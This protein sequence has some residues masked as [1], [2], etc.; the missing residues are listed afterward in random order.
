MDDR[1]S[2][3]LIV[4]TIKI[5]MFCIFILFFT[6][7]IVATYLFLKFPSDKQIKGC[8]IT[9]FNKVN[10]CA[11]SENYVKLSEISEYLIKAVI[12]TEDTAFYSHSGFD[13]QEIVN[14]FKLN[15]EKGKFARGGSTISQQLAKNLFLSK[16]KTLSRKLLE[17]LITM[18]IEKILSKREILEKYLNV[19]QFG[20]DLYGVKSASKFYF[21][22]LPSQLSINE[23]AFLA[24]LLPNPEVYSKSYFQGK[25]TAFA[26]NR[27]Q[28]I[29]DRLLSFKKI[30]EN[31][32]FQA[33]SNVDNFLRGEKVETNQNFDF[34]EE[35]FLDLESDN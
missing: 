3:R 32:Y 23:S 9:S 16:D 12:S 19:V 31:E 4:K 10:L 26:R 2:R 29:I 5:L 14:S 11:K 33:N 15:L 35:E 30:S 7:G 8:L 20:K 17:A 21:N 27:I 34:S 13:F 18:R 28:Q 24:F 22:K 25:L 6:V 1:K